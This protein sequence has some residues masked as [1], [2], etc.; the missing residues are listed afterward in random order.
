ML[1]SN[2]ISDFGIIASM[3]NPKLLENSKLALLCC[4]DELR[5]WV[6]NNSPN[7][8]SCTSTSPFHPL[9]LTGNF[10][11]TVDKPYH[12]PVAAALLWI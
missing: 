8:E 10:L 6:S 11:V 7:S 3:V 5:G 4:S 1:L 12:K 2:L 9:E